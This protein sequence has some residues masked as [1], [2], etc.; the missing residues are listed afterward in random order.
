M[1]PKDTRQFRIN[2]MSRE[3]LEAYIKSVRKEN[4]D[5]RS[6]KVKIKQRYVREKQ[7]VAGLKDQLDSRPK[8]NL[9]SDIVYIQKTLRGQI[10][11]YK[12]V[13]SVSAFVAL[14]GSEWTADDSHLPAEGEYS[15]MK[16]TKQPYGMSEYVG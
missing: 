8:S 10:L 6:D 9:A 3:E 7:K 14:L 12:R 2:E 5:L 11:G 13:R 16:L 15:T 4:A 1:P